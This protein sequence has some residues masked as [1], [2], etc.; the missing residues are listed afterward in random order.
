MK[1]A[2]TLIHGFLTSRLDHCK[3]L[4]HGLPTTSLNYFT[5]VLLTVL[6]ILADLSVLAPKLMELPTSEHSPCPHSA[7]SKPS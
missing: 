7:S 5:H 3:A 6:Y 2:E 4:F 1:D